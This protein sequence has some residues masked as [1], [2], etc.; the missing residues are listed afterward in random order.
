MT[1]TNHPNWTPRRVD[2]PWLNDTSEPAH[3]DPEHRA[4]PDAPDS[5]EPRVPRPG[6]LT[7]RRSLTQIPPVEHPV[8]SSIAPVAEQV[9]A[10]ARDQDTSEAEA[11][12]VWLARAE[13]APV[14]A[15]APCPT[16]GERPTPVVRQSPS[17]YAR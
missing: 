6:E 15:P 16:P 10:P 8:P 5:G 12:D 9:A 7:P 3:P 13:A 4:G 11:L 14:P 17:P 2:M 1:I